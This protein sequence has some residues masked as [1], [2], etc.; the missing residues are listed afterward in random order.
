MLYNGQKRLY[1]KHIK[2]TKKMLLYNQIHKIDDNELKIDANLE[3]DIKGIF[4]LLFYFYFLLA[5]TK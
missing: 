5:N 4:K 1:Q 3:Y 2:F